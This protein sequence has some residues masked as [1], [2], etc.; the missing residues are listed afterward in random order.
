MIKK[1]LVAAAMSIALS[2]AMLT[3]AQAAPAEPRDVLAIPSVTPSP[4][5]WLHPRDQAEA[6]DWVNNCADGRYC[7]WIR[8]NTGR[9]SF[10]QFYR[11]QEYALSNWGGTSNYFNNQRGATVELRG[12]RHNLIRT[13]SPG[14]KFITN[15]DPVWFINLCA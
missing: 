10:F 3:P 6:T 2:A 14:S 13:H 11:C 1:F 7:T 4:E 12:E 9:Y 5:H 8:S 15:W